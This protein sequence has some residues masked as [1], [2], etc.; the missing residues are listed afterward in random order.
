MIIYRNIDDLIKEATLARRTTVL[1]TYRSIKC[2]FQAHETA[3]NAKP[4]D[5]VIEIE[6]LKRLEKQ[7][8]E[9]AEIF[10]ANGRMDLYEKRMGEYYI[11]NGMLPQEPS[12]K[13][14]IDFVTS[15][16]RAEQNVSRKNM[17]A[18]IKATKEKY[19]TADGKKISTIVNE[20]ILSI[21]Q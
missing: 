3:K 15:L 9:S 8:L 6:I 18:F 1:E 17:G 2:A 16:A 10:K 13:E 7:A 12:D 20:V 21:T 19:P 5:D 4:I 14:L 11:I